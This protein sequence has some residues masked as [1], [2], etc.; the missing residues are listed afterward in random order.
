MFVGDIFFYSY[1]LLGVGGGFS[2]LTPPWRMKA[3][4]TFYD[5]LD[6]S[7]SFSGHYYVS[8]S[9]TTLGSPHTTSPAFPHQAERQAF[10][11]M[12]E[13]QLHNVRFINLFYCLD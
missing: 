1:V 6:L 8:G 7:I 10:E 12:R 3:I 9:F 5:M 2:H 13:K 4:P 11:E